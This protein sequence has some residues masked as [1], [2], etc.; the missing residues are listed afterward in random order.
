MR[1]E[2]TVRG[3]VGSMAAPASPTLRGFASFT[4]G[5]LNGG[6][7]NARSATG[8]SRGYGSLDDAVAA[9]RRISRGFVPA[10]AVFET[11]EGRYSLA[12]VQWEHDSTADPGYGPFTGAY[13]VG[14]FTRNPDTWPPARPSGRTGAE[15]LTPEIPAIRAVVDGAQMIVPELLPDGS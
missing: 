14:M 13:H 10:V 9:A 11:A 7:L 12:T 6:W 1:I 3:Q 8:D 5:V 15:R 2:T 4:S